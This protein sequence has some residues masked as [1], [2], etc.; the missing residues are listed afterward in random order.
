MQTQTTTN[1]TSGILAWTVKHKGQGSPN[2]RESPTSV[3]HPKTPNRQEEEIAQWKVQSTLCK[4]ARNNQW[5]DEYNTTIAEAK[6][7]LALPLA[8][9]MLFVS[10]AMTAREGDAGDV[11]KQKRI[12]NYCC[13]FEEKKTSI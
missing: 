5:K 10:L 11:S 8:P 9:A 13:N 1:Q 2:A 6:A 3:I 4:A 7:K 12:N